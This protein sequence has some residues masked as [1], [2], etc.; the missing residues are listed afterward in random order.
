MQLCDMTDSELTLIHSYL[1]EQIASVE[2]EQNNR[3]LRTASWTESAD[4]GN[5]IE[6]IRILRLQKGWSLMKAHQIVTEYVNNRSRT[7]E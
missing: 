7:D 5:K 6:A 4:R 3:R 1:S 2:Y